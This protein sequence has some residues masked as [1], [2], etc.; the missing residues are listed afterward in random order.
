MNVFG[1]KGSVLL[2]DRV[3][4]EPVAAVFRL[5]CRAPGPDLRVLPRTPPHEAASL[6]NTSSPSECICSLTGKR[7]GLEV[8]RFSYSSYDAK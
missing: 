1:W 6:A 7:Q 8:R 4:Y 3:I 2:H 5:P